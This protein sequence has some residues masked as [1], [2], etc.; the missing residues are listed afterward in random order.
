MP[1][2]PPEATGACLVSLRTR[3]LRIDHIGGRSAVHFLVYSSSWRAKKRASFCR[4]RAYLRYQ[5]AYHND[6]QQ[7]KIKYT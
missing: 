5:V 1:Q 2:N 4:G 7:K 3:P 6:L